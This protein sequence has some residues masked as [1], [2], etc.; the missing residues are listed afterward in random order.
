MASKSVF[1]N[2]SR[3]KFPVADTVNEA[4]GV[5]YSRTAEEALSQLAVTG[6]FNNVFYTSAEDQLAKTQELANQCSSVFLAKLA[7]YAR[8][9]G[10]MKDM[11]AYLLA[12]LAARKDTELLKKVFNRVINNAKMLCNFVQIVRSGV[13][14]RKSFGTAVKKMIQNWLLSRTGDQLFHDSVGHSNPSIGDIIKMVHPKAQ[15]K[16]TQAMFAYILGREYDSKNLPVKVRAFE[17]FKKDNTKEVPEVDFRL[18]S[19]CKLTPDNWKQIVMNMQWN[20]LRMNLNTAA[21]NGV[22]SDSDT[23]RNVCNKLS[24]KKLV[25]KS[26]AFPYQLLQAFKSVE[27]VPQSV[28]NAL[29]DAMEHAVENVPSFN[30]DGV[31][32]CV[33][34]SGSM[35]S[36]VTG[37]RGSVT[38]ATRCVDVAGLVASCILRKNDTAIAVPFDTEVHMV[39][40]NPRDS[41]MTNAQKLALNGGGTDC[42]S[43]LRYLNKVGHKGDLV[44]YV[45]DNESWVQSAGSR[46]YGG[47]GMN[48]EWVAF[49]KRNPK[50][51]LVLID[52]QPY[53]TVQVQDNKDVL[54]VGG[55]SDS[56]FEI[57]NAFVQG[58]SGHFVDV[59]SG[60]TID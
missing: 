45:S 7:V 1:Q 14:G 16:V 17:A 31:A 35:G 56:V 38:T 49:K 53:T 3:A 4:G 23:T 59:I 12:V 19:N 50:A 40:I 18:L 44:V 28:K 54:N 58:D 60:V 43:A 55:F 34:T 6:C 2:V 57:I 8:Q 47:T 29:Q 10:K 37:N 30:I 5:A 39:S 11:P 48:A 27:N 21:R 13:T 25:Q 9:N 24:N 32:I 33:D 20:T 52:L 46:N 26:N 15:A 42:G 51:K 36:P 41:V 22:F